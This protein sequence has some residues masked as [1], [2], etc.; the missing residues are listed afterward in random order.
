V[1][2]PAFLTPFAG[3]VINLHPAL[4]ETFPGTEAI[5][6]A[7]EAYQRREITHSGCMMHYVVPEVDAGPVIC[8][9]IVPI[10]AEDSLESFEARMHEAEHRLIVEAIDRVITSMH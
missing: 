10:Q 8:Q 9:T 5:Q 3:K 7:F 6:R 1:I 4:P 2:S